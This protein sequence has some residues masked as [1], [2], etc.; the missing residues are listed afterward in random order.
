[1]IAESWKHKGG[2]AGR[3]CNCGSWKQHWINNSGL[4]WPHKCSVNGC[5]NVATDGAHVINDNET[6]EWIVPTC[7]S[8]NNKKNDI[9]DL[10]GGITLVRANKSL[11]CEK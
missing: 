9:F 4:K 6:G 5:S 10:K 1:M 3:E 8:C 7:T 11:T 2:T